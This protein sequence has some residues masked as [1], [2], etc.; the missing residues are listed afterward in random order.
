MKTLQTL[1]LANIYQ[2]W[3]GLVESIEE[4]FINK[5]GNTLVDLCAKCDLRIING[6]SL[7]DLNRMQS[8]FQ[9]N[10]KSMVDYIIVNDC[11]IPDAKTI[12]VY[13]PNHLSDHAYLT[14][15]LHLKLSERSVVEK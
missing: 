6:R 4:H 1:S 7:G 12:I 5:F 14:T 3:K 15:M 9:Y 11:L 8:C 13:N 10:G 2:H